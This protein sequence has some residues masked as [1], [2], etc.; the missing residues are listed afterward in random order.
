MLVYNPSITSSIAALSR[1]LPHALLLTG[2]PGVGL[3]TLALHLAGAQTAA[4]IEPLDKDGYVN[5]RKGTI[6]VT[7]IRDLYTETQGKSATN[8]VYVIDNADKMSA[9]AANAFLKLLEEPNAHTHFILTSHNPSYLPATVLSRT[10]RLIVPPILPEQSTDLAYQLKLRGTKA[11]QAL[12]I[13]SGL[14]AELARLA[15][16]PEY[17]EQTA[18]TMAAAKAYLMGSRL[19]RTVTV[20]QY[21]S[22]R[23]QS[24]QLLTAAKDIIL[25]TAATKPS[26]EAVERAGKLASAYDAIMAN[27]N[28]KLHLIA[29]MV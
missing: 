18:G 14:P 4:I 16:S 20:F 25:H 27:G 13:A 12:F 28:P 11:Q 24:L 19:E 3:R 29:A 22:D 21:G 1:Q 17:F 15:A 7:R 6:S 2:Q 8:R 10:Q 23:E 9:G 5:T 26:A